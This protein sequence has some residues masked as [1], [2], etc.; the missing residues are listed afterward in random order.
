MTAFMILW[1]IVHVSD[2]FFCFFIFFVWKKI[3]NLGYLTVHCDCIIIIIDEANEFIMLFNLADVADDDL[4][5]DRL[6]LNGVE[7]IA[8]HKCSHS[9]INQKH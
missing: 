9:S 7:C 1:R 6:R 3:E 4:S 8:I 5:F 2:V